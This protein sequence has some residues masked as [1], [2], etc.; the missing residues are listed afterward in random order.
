MFNMYIY[1][2]IMANRI[3][4]ILRFTESHTVFSWYMYIGI[5]KLYNYT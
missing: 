2:S 4:D 3:S 5:G 1:V